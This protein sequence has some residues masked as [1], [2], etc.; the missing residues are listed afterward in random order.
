MI[1]PYIIR[2]KLHIRKEEENKKSE[3]WQE[4]QKMLPSFSF[5][6]ASSLSFK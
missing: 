6:L 5:S 3:A 4:T 1:I 2:S